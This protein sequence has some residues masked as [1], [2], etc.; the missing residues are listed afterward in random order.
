VKFATLVAD[1][2]NEI[3]TNANKNKR[4]A[5]KDSNNKGKSRRKTAE[6]IGHSTYSNTPLAPRTL[7]QQHNIQVPTETQPDNRHF[8]TIITQWNKYIEALGTNPISLIYDGTT[9]KFFTYVQCLRERRALDIIWDAATYYIHESE[10][11]LKHIDIL[12]DFTTLDTEE[13]IDHAH[14]FGKK[15]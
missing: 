7:L 4:M 12:D 1:K 2:V 9:D 6:N 11:S 3:I 15:K 5:D 13:V 14:E 10:D 8:T